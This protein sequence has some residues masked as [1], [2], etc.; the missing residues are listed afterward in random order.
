MQARY[1][2]RAF[3]TGNIMAPLL[4]QRGTISLALQRTGARRAALFRR[5]AAAARIQ[6]QARS[7]SISTG[8]RFSARLH[9]DDGR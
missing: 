8:P 9:S 1:E 6:P 7:R 2:L 3:A 4:P 5:F